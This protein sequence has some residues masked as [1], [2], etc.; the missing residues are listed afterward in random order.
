M[1]EHARIM[2]A[3][4]PDTHH[5]SATR[6]AGRLYGR[7]S[8]TAVLASAL[9]DAAGRSPRLLSL[10]GAAGTGK[11]ALLARV[12]ADARRRGWTVL[13]GR[14]T[15]LETTNDFG[16]LR[17]VLSGLP[18]LPDG[19]PASSLLSVPESVSLF[20]VFELVSAHLLDVLAGAPVLI[21]VD[22]VQWCDPASLRWL[23]Y[24]TNR[25]ADL[26]LALVLAGSPGEK[27]EQRF[28]VDELI[29]SCE[30]RTCPRLTSAQISPW[31]T[32][33]MGARPDDAF[34][35]GC[36]RATG[37]NAALLTA[38]LPALAA[39]SV[40]PV[41]ASLPSI[42]SVGRAAVGRR[43]LPWI[44]R[45]GPE[46]PAVAQAVVVLGD[47][48][49]PALVAELAGLDLDAAAGVVDRLIKLDLLTDTSPLRYGC[50]L[51][52][53]AVDAGISAGLRTSQRLRAARMIRD[54]YADPERAAAHLMAVDVSGERWTLDL[55]RAAAGSALDKGLPRQA[56]GYLRRALAE[57]MPVST[58]AELLADI[59]SAEIGADSAG[60]ETPLL[61]ALTLAT[62][63]S[64]RVRIGVDLV[65]VD[66][67]AGRPLNTAL[68]IVDEACALVPPER[69][70]LVVEAEFG[71]FFASLGSADAGEFFERRL[72]RLRKLTAGDARLSVLAGMV[73]A[74]SR[75]RH[76]RDRA[77]CVHRARA[78]LEALDPQK[79]REL[80]LR[81][82]AVSALICAEEYDLADDPAEADGHV[83]H[84]QGAARDATIAACLRG[85]LLFG[86][87]DLASAR[88]ELDT[89]LEDPFAAGTIGVARLVRVLAE[90]GDLDTADRLVRDHGPAVPPV[91]TW[92]STAFAFAKAALCM[93][94]DQHDEA[95][96]GFRETGRSLRTLGI[97]N[98]GVFPWR[99]QAAR[100]SALLGD[101]RTAE[102]LA[103]EAVDL[104][105]R[106]GAPRA[107]ST[108]LAA[109]GVVDTDPEAALEA[110][111]VLDPV[112]ADFH[113]ATALVDLGA[114]RLAADAADRAHEPLQD[115]FALAHVINARPVR[116]RAARH[117]R[118]AGGKPDLGRISGVTAL[119][120]QERAAAERA[121]AG[122]TNRRIADDM[123][124][125]Q[126]TVEQYLTNAYR[127][128]GI[129]GRR[130][131]AAALSR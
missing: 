122:V 95:L 69:G 16:V 101:V 31:I 83:A 7:E 82:L 109:A 3:R 40:P 64:L 103:A 117:I 51:V 71:V 9:D 89:A 97:D 6:P 74:W 41:R 67:T 17:Q 8:E 59:G 43:V 25:S 11:S 78:A 128:L 14:A 27:C 4:E 88:T 115:G 23:A 60:A 112:D 32:D 34:V 85:H 87:G 39:R 104:A 65:G 20:A 57:A 45:G 54:H 15:I 105:R 98:P 28:L 113:R 42:E 13:P 123:V 5:G 91:P 93:V 30:R 106:W 19:R 77:E 37:G 110:V 53:A 73:D 108:A 18:P 1:R 118:R 49:E 26:P 33:I 66:A 86:R 21:T 63:P 131:L 36:H 29:A 68:K 72:P 80:R 58:R 75:L 129:S 46:A 56:V 61:E 79:P 130:Q 127:K 52:R 12:G 76:G 22:D 47:D 111:T 100:C 96:E 114:V 121:A 2:K 107:L 55:L 84:R 81:L 10:E 124:L 120:A 102:S 99:S 94:R 44:Q 50:S 24:L 62:E 125:T 92:A 126:R 90:L 70:E 35:E 48:S 119:T 116:L 38:L